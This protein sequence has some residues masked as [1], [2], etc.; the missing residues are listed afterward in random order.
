MPVSQIAIKVRWHSEGPYKLL[1]VGLA[2]GATQL[3]SDFCDTGGR[4]VFTV[5]SGTFRSGRRRPSTVL[6]YDRLDA[7]TGSYGSSPPSHDP[8]ARFNLIDLLA[9][10]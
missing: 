2:F 1:V 5:G 10:I 9:L 4:A 6:Q 7:S 8:T 3:G